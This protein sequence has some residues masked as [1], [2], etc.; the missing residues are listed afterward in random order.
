[1][2]RGN[3]HLTPYVVRSLYTEAML[4]ADE[5]RTYFDMDWE[6]ARKSGVRD[7]VLFGCESLKVATRLMHCVA[8]LLNQKHAVETPESVA[9][10]DAARRPLG[11]SAPSN[12][13]DL[14]RL[15]DEARI[16]IA[17][18]ESLY[19]RLVRLH[20]KL[21]EH[22]ERAM[23]QSLAEPPVVRRLQDLLRASF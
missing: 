9:L 13:E 3:T 17:Q 16:L 23:R 6:E 10:L 5:T 2:P 12:A 18:S 21:E 14:R 22:R 11:H 20:H 8:W 7:E 1:M 4:L 19:N 15:P